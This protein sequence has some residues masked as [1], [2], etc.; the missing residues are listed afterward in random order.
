[1]RTFRGEALAGRKR[2]A[3]IEGIERSGWIIVDRAPIAEIR[4][5]HLGL[6]TGR[7]QLRLPLINAIVVGVDVLRTNGDR[8]NRQ[9]PQN[10]RR[11][12]RDR[13][14][15][16]LGY[17]MG[18]RGR[19]GVAVHCCGSILAWDWKTKAGTPCTAWCYRTG[20]TPLP[21]PA[22]SPIGWPRPLPTATAHY[23]HGGEEGSEGRTSSWRCFSA[24]EHRR[25]LVGSA[26]TYL[27]FTDLPGHQTGG[28]V[29]GPPFGS[30]QREPSGALRLLS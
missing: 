30:I 3:A 16:G 23:T 5:S 10:R 26:R 25:P 19:G 8:K 1:M 12:R 21:T 14:Q 20:T 6:G 2:R 7:C 9:E 27:Y 11:W 28:L 18:R 29:P 4:K 22:P 13:W 24:D 17:R 15:S